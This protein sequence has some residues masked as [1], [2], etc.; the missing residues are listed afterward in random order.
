M[1]KP[2][3][4]STV[5]GLIMALTTPTTT[6]ISPSFALEKQGDQQDSG[7]TLIDTSSKLPGSF[8]GEPE[9]LATPQEEIP[10]AKV[11]GKPVGLV[12]T[13]NGNQVLLTWNKASSNSHI[14]GYEYRQKALS[15]S[16]G[17]WKPMGG[18]DGSSTSYTVMDLGYETTYEFQ[19]RAVNYE[20]KSSPSIG[21]SV[22]T[23][24]PAAP[25]GFNGSSGGGNQVLL[26]WDQASTDSDITGYEYRQKVDSSKSYGEWKPINGSDGNS[27]RYMVMHL[28]YATTYD[29]QVRAVSYQVKGIPSIMTDVTTEAPEQPAPPADFLVLIEPVRD[30]YHYMPRPRWTLGEPSSPISGYELR[31][32]EGDIR[33]NKV[34]K[35]WQVLNILADAEP[36]KGDAGLLTDYLLL[37]NQDYT[38]QLRA[39]TPIVKGLIS[40]TTVNDPYQQP[41]PPGPVSAEIV[42]GDIKL[43]WSDYTN[44][45]AAYDYEYRMKQAGGSFGPWT[46]IENS[47]PDGIYTITPQVTRLTHSAIIDGLEPGTIYTFEVRASL[48]GLFH[49]DY[50]QS[51]SASVTIPSQPAAPTNFEVSPQ[52]VSGDYHYVPWLIWTLVDSSSHISGYELRILE[53]DMGSNRIFKDWQVLNL[54]HVMPTGT[55]S[56]IVKDDLLLP[57]QDYTFQLRAFTPAVKGRIAEITV[58]YPPQQPLAP[59]PVSAEIVSGEVKLSWTDHTNGVAQYNYEYRMRK[60]GQEEGFGPWIMIENSFPDGTTSYGNAL[61]VLTY[62]T[63]VEDLEPGTAY[64]FEVRASLDGLFHLDYPDSPF[65]SIITPSQPAAPTNLE[66][67]P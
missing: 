38:F 20:A 7:G 58:N 47:F 54:D 8:L 11:P 42:N 52:F 17:E 2:L 56:V 44:G 67:S 46:M 61:T 27:T 37:P 23:P 45:V 26:Q 35:D 18:G 48:D 66:V 50:P 49:L 40:E 39:F 10:E 65:A 14:T 30:A 43:S 19:I 12:A 53:G 24:R 60:G 22:T 25:A 57:N 21:V 62:S 16:Y 3:F 34:F 36:G 9:D 63:I 41:F 6:P 29:F 13:A 59:A 32:L 51:P 64:T 31:V 4:S 33:S 28:D 5:L 55:G 1:A 15:K